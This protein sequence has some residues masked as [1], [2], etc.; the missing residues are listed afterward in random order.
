MAFRQRQVIGTVIDSKGSA[1]KNGIVTFLFTSPLGYT[2]THVVIDRIATVQTDTEGNFSIMLWCDEDSS[3]PVNY[4]VVFPI[5]DNGPSDASHKG[6]F[7]LHYSDTEVNVSRLIAAASQADGEYTPWAWYSA[8]DIHGKDGDIVTIWPDQTVYGRDLLLTGSTGPLYRVNEQNGLP[9]IEFDGASDHGY[10]GIV[11]PISI[12]HAFFV[13]KH[14]GA[15][16]ATLNR[17]CFGDI[18]SEVLIGTPDDTVWSAMSGTEYRRNAVID[19]TRTAP[20]EIYALIHLKFSEPVTFSGV[21]NIG[22][23]ISQGFPTPINLCEFGLY[24]DELPTK[25]YQDVEAGIMSKYALFY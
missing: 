24:V 2:P 11:D 3:V 19:A 15:T 20:M 8:E 22:N 4:T 25:T 18:D 16:F 10:R 17:M 21:V 12:Y 7:S 6:T 1:V 23:S 14:R 13:M 5:A 9:A